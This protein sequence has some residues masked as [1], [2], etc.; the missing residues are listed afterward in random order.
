MMRFAVKQNKTPKA[1]S[2]SLGD[3]YVLRIGLSECIQEL[4]KSRTF[5]GDDD[6]KDW[7]ISADEIEDLHQ[8][9]R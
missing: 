4:S 8:I 2:D 5:N 1:P 9:P 6:V 7:G 3:E